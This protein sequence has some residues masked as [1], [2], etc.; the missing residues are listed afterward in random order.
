M[1]SG[2]N[3]DYRHSP[4]LEPCGGNLD[5]VNEYYRYAAAAMRIPIEDV[6]HATFSWVTE[7]DLKAWT[8][9]DC[10]QN[11]AVKTDAFSILP[12]FH[13]EL[14]HALYY[15]A[16]PRSS[17]F[18]TEGFATAMDPL[19]LLNYEAAGTRDPRLLLTDAGFSAGFYAV[20]GLFVVYLLQTRGPEAFASLYEE[21]GREASLSDWEAAFEA[22]Y[23]EDLDEVIDAYLNDVDCPENIAPFPQFECGAPQLANTDGGWQFHRA[24]RCAES[25]V[26]G[27]IGENGYAVTTV[28]FQVDVAGDYDVAFLEPAGVKAIAAVGECDRCRWLSRGLS[29]GGGQTQRT[30]LAKG[31]HF[32]TVRVFEDQ[33]REVHVSVVPAE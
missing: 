29:V 2:P 8:D 28:T 25:D 23:G 10:E 16:N 24:L 1:L 15:D 21:L 14:A 7:G 33:E 30:T 18:L 32:M 3:V 12:T 19:Q 22:I 9:G 6:P 27:G 17:H 13:H 4:E 31:R 5:V 20:A 11:C 26:A